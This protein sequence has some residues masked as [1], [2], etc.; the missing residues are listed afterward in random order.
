MS[1]GSASS[2]RLFFF[3][4]PEAGPRESGAVYPDVRD[5]F[6]A[7]GFSERTV[8]EPWDPA[9]VGKAPGPET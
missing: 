2:R 6:R 7:N 8:S 3:L 5:V 1:K 4:F 9:L